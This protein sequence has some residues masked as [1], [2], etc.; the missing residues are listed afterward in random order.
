LQAADAAEQASR[1]REIQFV[2][3]T[4]R[5]RYSA[6]VEIPDAMR[7]QQL[8]LLCFS[9]A[10]SFLVA[11]S[12]LSAAGRTAAIAGE[13]KARTADLQRELL[14]RHAANHALEQSE[15]R[16]REFVELT[17]YAVVVSHEDRIIFANCSAA[18]MFGATTPEALH[19]RCLR[20]LV[21]PDSQPAAREAFDQ[22]ND[23]RRAQPTRS[24]RLRRL[25]GSAF[26]AEATAVP[27]E[28]DGR[29]GAL[30]LAQ[31]ISVRR[32]AEQQRDRFF[33]L[34]LDLLCIA[35]LDGYF[36][37]INPAFMATLGYTIEELLARPFLEFVHPDDRAATE[38]AV[39]GLAKGERVVSLENRYRCKDGSWVWLSWNSQSFPEEQ[40]IFATARDVTASHQASTELEQ[41]NADLEK[42][43][44]EA[45]RASRAKSDFLAAMSHEIRTPLNGVIGMVDVLHQTS[46]R[47]YQVEMVDLIRE[48]AW[49]LLTVIEDI[50]DFSKIEADRLELEVEPMDIAEVVKST[51]RM[52]E[53]V[54]TRQQ[55]ELTLFTDPNIPPLLLGDSVRLR[56]VLVNLVSNAVKFSSGLERRGRVALR[57]VLAGRKG[58]RVRVELRVTDNGIGI[59]TATLG[60]LFRPFTQADA[61]TTRR[62]GGTGLGLTISRRLVG[63]MGGEIEVESEPDKGSTFTVRIPFE[64]AAR[65]DAGPAAPP[66]LAGVSCVVIDG[67]HGRSADLD[68][69]LKH[70]RAI[71]R[72]VPDLA[73]A[74]RWARERDAGA[75]VWI[76]EIGDDMPPRELPDE[77]RAATLAGPAG[78]NAFLLIGRGGRRRPRLIAPDIVSV[79]LNG[80]TRHTFI[81]A[82][83]VAAGRMTPE[84]TLITTGKGEANL[85]PPS[86][87][88]S[89]EAGQLIL[90][91]EDNATNQKVIVRQL[92]LLGYAA[93]V[94]SDGRE[95]LD[96]WESGRYGLVLTDLHMP[97]LDGY[98]L[99]RAIRLGEGGD[100]HIPI[101]AISANALRG[102]IERCR[103]AQIDDYLPK[104]MP[105]D[106]L[107][108]MLGKWLPLPAAPPPPPPP[109]VD[110]EVLARYV[111]DDP[112]VLH[113]CL[114]GFRASLPLYMDELRAA[115]REGR[116]ADAGRC[117][118]RIKSAARTV[119][120]LELGD[121]CERVEH[122]GLRGDAE[123]VDRLLPRIE[124]LVGAAE[125]HIA[126][127]QEPE[128][129]L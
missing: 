9:V 47:G 111:G 102:E 62:F 91:V 97:K 26:P 104:P 84:S 38:A 120:A 46:L 107:K 125:A 55:V 27:Y 116:A 54:A 105:L 124:S 103:S 35:S 32:A 6:R 119:G 18:A 45:E 90:V 95:A 118:H 66:L 94:A 57:V 100:E 68:T 101:V 31:D 92:A 1:V 63:L 39:A 121:V 60:R 41:L 115:C 21:H 28:R 51:T 76:L 10:G 30:I 2:G 88:R 5:I 25:D 3:R 33:E 108:A 64:I 80:L 81:D 23:Q 22:L 79:D 14:A 82:V 87:R 85:R 77:L 86:R 40:L 24:I 13:V 67:T 11:L 99:A 72:R 83:A 36:R 89:A 59:D 53:T 110:L 15:A 65:A 58:D 44:F 98:D 123:A 8:L 129:T 61:S 12:T 112:A 109:A 96:C 48:S 50:L 127:L 4:W 114:M 71:V 34:S 20:D 106:D 73:A 7:L 56:Q 75:V 128:W 17:P 42:A 49:S 29:Q 70:D 37:R 19:G 78:S 74:C 93:D 122:K 16:Y 43:R 113:E 126:S 52:M 117:A 69:Y